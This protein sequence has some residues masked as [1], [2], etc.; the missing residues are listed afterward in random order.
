MGSRVKYLDNATLFYRQCKLAER[1]T[2]GAQWH[3]GPLCPCALCFQLNS[4]AQVGGVQRKLAAYESEFIKASPYNLELLQHYCNQRSARYHRCRLV[5]LHPVLCSRKFYAQAC[6]CF[7]LLLWCHYPVDYQPDMHT[8][9][10]VLNVV[11]VHDG[12]CQTRSLARHGNSASQGCCLS[13]E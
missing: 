11:S 7:G 1:I 9:Q 4:H 3:H 5:C 12:F 2:L 8:T 10:F 6:S 13:K